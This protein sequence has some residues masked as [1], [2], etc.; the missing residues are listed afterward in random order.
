MD[1]KAV[2]QLRQDYN[3]PDNDLDAIVTVASVSPITESALGT[4]KYYKDKQRKKDV[5]YNIGRG[6]ASEQ[7]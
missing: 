6:I 7:L 1:N 3:I 5:L 4:S 2:N